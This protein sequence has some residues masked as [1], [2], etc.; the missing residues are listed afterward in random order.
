MEKKK[1][2]GILMSLIFSVIL[3]LAHDTTPVNAANNVGYQTSAI[4]IK[5][6]SVNNASYDRYFTFEG[7]ST[8]EQIYLFLRGPGGEI[9]TYPVRV[10]NGKFSQNV[11]L[12]FGA[13]KYMVWVGDNSKR[14]DGKI[15]FQVLN[16]SR[17]NY[18]NL[19]PSGFVNSDNTAIRKIAASLTN[20]NMNDM[21][22]VKAIHNWVTANIAYDTD[23]YFTGNL[24]IHTA[25]DVIN[26][27][28]G[29]CA[30]YSF[31]FAALARAA[32]VQTKVIY[33]DAWNSA[34]Q[35]YEEHAWNESLINGQW[36]SIDTTWDAG[37]IND[38]T[39]VAASTDKYLNMNPE[40]FNQTH[41]KT[42]VTLY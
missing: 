11:W 22:K 19:S 25:L 32:G 36:I 41:L 24:E 12:R 6:P 26:S 33:G 15:H 5:S 27:K 1:L 9:T 34:I 37:Y 10:H 2:S 42:L 8:L 20:K 35:K 17:E 16:T 31:A 38:D 29:V 40:T 14:F 21:E 3:F 13:G 7:T 39:F 23:A 18:F 30:D 4:Q 28:K